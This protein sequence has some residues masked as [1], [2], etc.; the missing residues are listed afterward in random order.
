MHYLLLG[1]GKTDTYLTATAGF[2]VAGAD[3]AAEF[4]LFCAAEAG[5]TAGAGFMATAGLGSGS[6]LDY[7]EICDILIY[8]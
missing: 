6:I 2:A 8:D 1:R 5:I 7:R 4:A 3:S